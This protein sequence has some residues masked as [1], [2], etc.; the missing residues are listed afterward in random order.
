[1]W[2]GVSWRGFTDTWLVHLVWPR[3]WG[4]I[5]LIADVGFPAGFPRLMTVDLTGKLIQGA[6]ASA[7][8]DALARSLPASV[9]ALARRVASTRRPNAPTLADS[10]ALTQPRS[11]ACVLRL[12]TNMEIYW[13]QIFSARQLY[14][15]RPRQDHCDRGRRTG[16]S[17]RSRPPISVKRF[18]P[19]A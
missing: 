11:P 6:S 8:G 14:G 1:M 5:I 17:L 2:L 3:L 13:D 16:G 10:L 4:P 12:R 15:H 7:G 18:A 9:G 19:G